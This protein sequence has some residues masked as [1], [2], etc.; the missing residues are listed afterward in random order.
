MSEPLLSG[1]R[2]VDLSGEP[3]QM[4]GRILADLGAEVLKVEPPDGDPLR[5]IGPFIGQRRDAEASL[6]FAAWNAGKTSLVCREDAP[7][8]DEVL[9]GADVVIDTPGFPG[10]LQLA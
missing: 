1:V 10:S 9:A 6:R 7:E 3:A 8:L 2:V 5:R 4:G